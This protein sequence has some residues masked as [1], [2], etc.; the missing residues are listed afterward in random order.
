MM[1]V[2]DFLCRMGG[3]EFLLIF[4]SL[5][6]DND[7]NAIANEIQELVKN[8]YFNEG[9]II[10]STTSIGIASY[11]ID[12]SDFDSI[13]KKADMAMYYAKQ[14]GRD[15]FHLYDKEVN[16]DVFDTL[17]LIS[18]MRTALK[19][20]QFHL[21]FQPKILLADDSVV[22]AEALIRWIH[23]THGFIGPDI[24]IPIAEKSG[25]IID[26]GAWVIEQSCIAC[27]EWSRAG[28]DNISVAINMS[29]IQFN[30]HDIV[31]QI[32]NSIKK[33]GVKPHNIELEVTESLLLDNTVTLRDTLVQIKKMGIKISIDDFG[34]GYSNLGY[35]KTMDVNT[36]KIDRSFIQNMEEEEHNQNIV[37]AIIQISKS[38]GVQVV[39]EGVETAVVAES[40]QAMNC[41]IGQGYFWAKPLAEEKFLAFLE[42]SKI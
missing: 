19:D 5:A 30:E 4:N 16:E 39:A 21:V 18:D 11:P 27:S 12:G 10:S 31:D 24:F 14:I 37:K 22:G 28:F 36:L 23:P 33:S 9:Q 3:D 40:L 13:V 20:N 17:S 38:L 32:S 15:G 26:I 8:P 1:S 42:D 35:L 7:A 29:S 34:T 2:D 41:Q 25:L 6:T